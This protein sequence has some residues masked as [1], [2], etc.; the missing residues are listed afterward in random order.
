MEE[1]DAPPEMDLPVA[2][3]LPASGEGQEIR[4]VRQEDF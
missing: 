1:K 3:H 4:P 2:T